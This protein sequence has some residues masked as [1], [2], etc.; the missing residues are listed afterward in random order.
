[1]L[2]LTPRAQQILVLARQ[3][4]ERLGQKLI[5]TEHILLALMQMPQ[6]IAVGILRDMNVDVDAICSEIESRSSKTSSDSVETSD[7]TL[8]PLVQRVLVAAANEAS[9]LQH[10]YIGTE[11][12]LLGIL[13][14]GEGIAAELLLASGV[15]IEKC[16]QAILSALDPNFVGPDSVGQDDEDD[17]IGTSNSGMQMRDDSSS[18]V[19][20]PALRA[21][22][23]DLTAMAQDGVL[24]PVIGREKEITRVLQILCRRSKNNPVLVGEAGVGKTAIVEGLAQAIAAQ[25]VPEPLIGKRIITLDMALMLAGTKYRGQFEE[26]MKAVMDDIR[27][28]KNIILFLD[29]LH[30]IV[31]AGTSSEGSMDA[32]NILKPALSRGEIQCVGAT[33]LDEYRKYIEKDSALERRFQPVKVDAASIEDSINILHG[34]KGC[35]EKHHSVTYTD[36]AVE[37]AVKLSARYIQDRFLPDKAIDVIDEAGARA[38]L[39]GMQPSPKIDKLNKKIEQ[40]RSEKADAITAQDY[41]RAAQLRDDEKKYIEE[42]ESI[43]SR[44][45]KNKKCISVGVDDILQVISSWSGVPVTR[46]EKKES[47]RLLAMDSILKKTVIGQDDAVD[48][49]VRAIRRS[50]TDLNDPN[51]PIGSFLFL[52]PTG[53]GKT[54]LAKMLAE[55]MFGNRDAIIQVDMSEYMEKHSVSRMVGSPPGYVG[56]EEGGQLTEMIRR[57]PYSVILLDEIEKA[58]PDVLQIL[59]QVLEDGHMTDGQGRVV[60]FKNTIVIMTSNVGAEILQR[61]VG[62][63]FGMSNSQDNGFENVKN[64]ILDESK[65]VFKPEFLNRLTDIVVFR[66]LDGI[67]LRKIVDVE[68]EKVVKRAKDKGFEIVLTDSAKE[69]LATKGYD[70]KFGARPLKRAIEKNIEDPLSDRLLVGDIADGCVV[71]IAHEKCEKTLTFDV[72]KQMPAVSDKKIAK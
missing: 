3:E 22:G 66:Q 51:K 4:A 20:T 7:M 68:I 50:R 58:H 60:D 12:I 63:G 45:K 36:D 15:K 72:I 2:N 29:E 31:G 67:A 38:R 34:V 53:V 25:K 55:Q 28:A 52:G 57:K 43:L 27:R 61:D 9:M 1:M 48:S 70:K 6:C 14:E 23:R 41:E 54:Y 16:R 35:Y 5:G 71:R 37:S 59:L 30:T 64:A 69:F 32:S 40:V 13:R 44:S 10:P 49:I 8:S 18:N 47:E 46:L 56:H 17:D 21:F 19:K 11:H 62:L 39:R 65:K 24:D 26:R 42:K 33:T